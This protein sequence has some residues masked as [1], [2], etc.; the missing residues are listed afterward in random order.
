MEAKLNAALV[1]SGFT[2][3]THT[4]SLVKIP[5]VSVKAVCDINLEAAKAI[6]ALVPDVNVYDNFN[7]MLKNEKIDILYVCIPPFAHNGEVEKAAGKGIHIFLEKPIALTLERGESMVQAVKKAG[8]VTHVGYHM[9]YGKAVK[10]LKRLIESGEAGRPTLFDGCFQCNSL[11][12]DWWQAKDKSGGQVFEQVI[13]I[14][15]LAMYLFGDVDCV[16]GYI[17]NLAH[18]TA[19]GY[20]VEDTSVSLL[21]FKNGALANISGT[22]CPPPGRWDNPFSVVCENITAHFAANNDAVFYYTKKDPVQELHVK[23]DPDPLFRYVEETKAFINAVRGISAE[24]A[25]IAEGLKGLKMVD[26]VSRSDGKLTYL[27]G[28]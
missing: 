11:H 15:D 8:V 25:C 12:A 10:D 1:G 5:E 2:A 18:K 13:H 21:K 26:A 6:T 16:S 20:T 9:R 3:Q 17:A 27:Q 7:V 19:P 24:N 23:A 4:K 14:Y 22:N 28:E